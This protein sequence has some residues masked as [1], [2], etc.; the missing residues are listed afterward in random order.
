MVARP[1]TVVQM[2][3]ELESG[4]VER[5]TLEM[6]KYLVQLGH[7]SIVISGGG[8][9]VS[10]LVAEGSEH[11][12]WNIGKK[13]PLTLRYIS[14]LR[15]FLTKQKVDILHLRSR[16]PAW[17]GYMAWKSLPE[18]SRPRLVT[19]FHGFYSVNSY[20]AIMAKGEKIIAISRAIKSHIGY[21]Y[22]VPEEKI[23]LI[24]RG[25]DV[26]AFDPHKLSSERIEKLR[27][28]W[29]L[30][31]DARPVIMLPGR[32]TKWKGHEVFLKS[33]ILIKDLQW[34]AICVGNP[35]ENPTYYKYLLILIDRLQLHNQVK[36]VGQ[37]DDMPAAYLLA[38]IVI[39]A[40]SSE[41]EAFGR[42]SVEAQVMGKP[43]IATAHGG[44][45]ETVLPGKTGWLV[46]PE[47]PQSLADALREALTDQHQLQEF[48]ENGIDWVHQN[49]TTLRMCEE[50]VSLY[51]DLLRQRE[52]L[53]KSEKFIITSHKEDFKKTD[54]KFINILHL[55]PELEEG[56][57]ERHVLMLSG[58]QQKDG[59]EVNVVSAGG[60][61]V[62]QLAKGVSHIRFPVHRKNPLVGIYCAVRL[63]SLIRKNKIE[64]IHAHSRV[65]AWIAM[66]AS[67]ISA[68]P[69]IV[70]AHAYFS[71]QTQWIYIPYRRANT[72]ICVSKSV[73]SGMKNCFAENTVVIRNGLPD[74]QIT[75][76]GSGESE[77]NFLFVGR[78]T[79]LKGLQDILKIAPLIQGSWKLD[80]LGDG[81]LRGKLEEMV[82]SLKLEEKVIFHG[83]QDDPDAWM[84]RSDCLL[85]P[86]YIEGMP[87][88]LARAVQIGLP[89]I[90]SDI[91][92]I[93]EMALGRNGLVKPGDE[94]GWKNAIE[95]FFVTKESPEDFDKNAI[96]TI[97]QM[98]QEVQSV[99][100]SVISPEDRAH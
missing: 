93:R 26:D 73:Q 55:L 78:L 21:T 9:L 85:F 43:V 54:D 31:K 69:Y 47:D 2:L 34:K 39:S 35:A 8:R 30:S 7:R 22:N 6:G 15:R 74:V 25:V 64:V 11:V 40:S 83:F 60:K 38:D 98:T 100:D 89:V 86:S 65:P 96:P 62:S 16:M 88:T 58:Q 5:G 10:Q 44:S 37:C 95:K 56:G 18:N 32:I 76:K 87:L 57:V 91:E 71:T 67:R 51:C 66:F 53:S 33:L 17:I 41:A 63:A 12:L 99:Y 14:K 23:T 92:P 59:H 4:G 79:Q 68:K 13:G 72:V 70:T 90:A 24:H 29:G 3:P 28:V 50:T 20:S 80:I 1:F 42:V 19:T 81:P 75:W 84:E 97:L 61:L 94:V 82:K 46:K 45:L 52:E 49:F 36:F 27:D 48:G 77:V